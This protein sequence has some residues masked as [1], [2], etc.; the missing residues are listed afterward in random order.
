MQALR[1]ANGQILAGGVMT[2]MAQIISS[3]KALNELIGITPI[4]GAVPNGFELRKLSQPFNP[5]TSIRFSLPEASCETDRVQHSWTGNCGLVNERLSAGSYEY[6]FDAGRLTSEL[7][8][9]IRPNSLQTQKMILAIFL[10]ANRSRKQ[11]PR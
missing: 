10:T 8:L 1:S 9:W 5:S 6:Q 11:Q 4:S 2:K 3:S 7:F